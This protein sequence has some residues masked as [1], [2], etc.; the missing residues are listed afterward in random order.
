MSNKHKEYNSIEW[1][2]AMRKNPF[3]AKALGGHQLGSRVSVGSNV[4]GNRL[5]NFT[6]NI[7]IVQP[8]DKEN[9]P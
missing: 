9:S 1:E 2:E 6:I 5:E 4:S 3:L 8:K 7:S